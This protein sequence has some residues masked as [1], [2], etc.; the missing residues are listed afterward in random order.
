MRR[1]NAPRRLLSRRNPEE[2]ESLRQPSNES[3]EWAWYETLQNYVL[4][5]DPKP[6]SKVRPQ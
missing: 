4:E 3:I 2:F 1:G 6:K 5:E